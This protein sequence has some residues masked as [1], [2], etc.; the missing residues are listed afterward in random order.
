MA[1]N[2]YDNT[3]GMQDTAMPPTE[4]GMGMEGE[5]ETSATCLH[6]YLM[7]DGS[8]RVKEATG[9]K[10]PEGA[11]TLA[12]LEEVMSRAQEYFTAPQEDGQDPMGAAKAG[13][14]KTAKRAPMA[15]PNPGG[16][17]GE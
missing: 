8:Y 17:F 16:L 2:T 5:G 6:V 1:T 4:G 7:E 12:S 9:E 14:A 11:E 3:G 13:Y 10:V 15:A